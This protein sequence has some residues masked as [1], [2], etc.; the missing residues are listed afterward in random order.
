VQVIRSLQASSGWVQS[1][2]V[3]MR[4]DERG[5][6]FTEAQM[7]N[8][9][10]QDVASMDPEK[11]DEEDQHSFAGSLADMLSWGRYTEIG[12]DGE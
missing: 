10:S 1:G 5:K 9:W 7:P 12:E 11:V 6:P 4:R 3:T 2:L 8:Q